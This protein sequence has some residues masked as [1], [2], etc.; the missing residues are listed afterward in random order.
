MED[1]HFEKYNLYGFAANMTP[2][3]YEKTN[4]EELAV[5]QTHLTNKQQN[6]LLRLWR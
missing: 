4:P 3:K 5:K 1:E 2:A 6:N